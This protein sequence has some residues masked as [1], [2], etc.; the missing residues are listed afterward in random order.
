MLALLTMAEATPAPLGQ[1]AGDVSV[2]A[3][4]ASVAKGYNS[5]TVV[6]GSS[7]S[8]QANAGCMRYHLWMSTTQVPDVV[9]VTNV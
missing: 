9:L 6:S 1:A 4:K 8:F 5:L 2:V 7:S 3:S